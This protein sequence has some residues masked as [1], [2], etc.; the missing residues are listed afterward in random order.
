MSTSHNDITV[1]RDEKTVKSKK[2]IR[3]ATGLCFLRVYPDP[4]R[5][6]GTGHPPAP[7]DHGSLFLLPVVGGN[8]HRCR[9]QRLCSRYPHLTLFSVLFAI[10]LVFFLIIRSGLSE[11][12]ADPSLTIVQMATGIVLTTVILHY[13]REL[14]GAMLSI[15]FMVMT[16]G[17]FA[18]D[19]RRQMAMAGFTL[20]CFTLLQ[21]YE[22]RETPSRP[23]FRF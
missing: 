7:P 16:F 18:L 21:I 6:T 19:R 4:R 3:P 20:L 15:Y 11:R 13:T 23:F 5:P 2:A 14:R 22:W 10:N 8:H 17:I 9:A 12:F 1:T